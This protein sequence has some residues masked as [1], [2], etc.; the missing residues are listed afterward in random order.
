M[1][2][3][4]KDA[5][6]P[7]PRRRSTGTRVLIVAFMVLFLLCT[8]VYLL[9]LLHSK[10]YFLVV[11]ADTLV[12][13]KG[14]FFP[15][16]NETYR[17][18]D[19]AEAALYAAIP[20][21]KGKLDYKEKEFED[22]ASANHDF[23]EV[24]ISLAQDLLISKEAADFQKG[25]N[26]LDRARSLKGLDSKQL[27]LIQAAGADIDYLEAQRAYLGVEETLREAQIKFRKAETLGSGKFTDAGE[28]VLKI[29]RLLDAIKV[30]K[31]GA[32]LPEVAPE[33]AGGGAKPPLE[34][35]KTTPLVDQVETKPVPPP[36]PPAPVAP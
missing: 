8:I 2:E 33:P 3:N 16:G 13:K 31:S 10:K 34:P 29:Q 9:S 11:E 36:S 15:M 26:Y 28:W 17:P 4:E 21:P 14:I 32:V 7:P 1:A 19:P 35:P 6:P 24:L 27:R 18:E 30:I 12:V 25:K 5:L 23:G 22:L 20:V